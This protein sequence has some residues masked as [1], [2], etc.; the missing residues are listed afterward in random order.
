MLSAWPHV[1]IR[2]IDNHKSRSGVPD[3]VHSYKLVARVLHF[4]FLLRT[5][6]HVRSAWVMSL[7]CKCRTTKTISNTK[8]PPKQCTCTVGLTLPVHN[9]SN[10]KE[11]E[12]I[13]KSTYCHGEEQVELNIIIRN[14]DMELKQ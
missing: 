13:V 9:H 12:Y 3:N 1:G 5:K 10:S 8:E 2:S 11:S 7:P 4:Y 14:A 6:R